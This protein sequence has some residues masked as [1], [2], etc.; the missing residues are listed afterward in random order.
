M[1]TKQDPDI[2]LAKIKKDTLPDFDSST[3]DEYAELYEK[4]I[5]W[6]YRRELEFPTL[7]KLLGD[8][9]GLNILDFGC[10]PGTISRWLVSRGAKKII[11]LDISEG[12][13][14]YGRRREE[15]EKKGINYISE[16][17][18][19]YNEY[20]DIILAIYV[21]PYAANHETLL[22][23][24]QTMARVLKPGGRLITLPMHPDFN[25]DPEYYRPCGIRLVETQPRRD[26]STVQLHICQPPY[27]IDIQ[28]YYWSRETL[29]NTLQQAGFP[30]INW[31]PLE[32]PPG[33]LSPALT[34]Y[35][36]CPHA[37]ILECIRG[38]AC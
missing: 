8:T 16:L 25:S 17:D 32:L 34:S 26:G 33:D 38:E 31:K 9:T 6:P 12:M 28:A 10:G 19:S 5:S 21:M 23:M 1:I 20:F 24:S 36:Q 14:N 29:K 2:S 30:I 27:D 7:D 18:E 35:I 4:M 13:L 11:G 3:F 15:K 37:A 22:A